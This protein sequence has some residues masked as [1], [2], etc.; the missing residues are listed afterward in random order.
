MMRRPLRVVQVLAEDAI[1]GTEAAVS[2]FAEILPRNEVDATVVTFSGPGPVAKGRR[3]AGLSTISLESA[4]PMVLRRALERLRPDVAHAYGF[5]ASMLTRAVAASVSG[6]KA[7]VGVRG[8][9]NLDCHDPRSVRARTSLRAEAS[10][11]RLVA[12]Y[13]A[14]SQGA[15]DL[16]VRA[17]VHSGKVVLNH[18]GV[19]LATWC[20]VRREGFDPPRLVCVARL[21]SL[22]GHDLLLRALAVLHERGVGPPLTLV[23]DGI[24]REELEAL[25][26]R[27]D[28]AGQIRFCGALDQAGVRH[29]LAAA[30][31]FC[32]AS[33]S[34]GSPGAVLEAMATG[35]PVVGTA[36]NGISDAVRDGVTGALVRDRTPA[37][38]AVALEAVLTA[39]PERRAAMGA[40][41]RRRVE[42]SFSEA[43]MVQRRLDLYRRVA[44]AR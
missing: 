14:N 1:G 3:A 21:T 20:P 8:L 40:A 42:H 19:D 33:L 38:F 44:G 29:E 26:G 5:R 18:N 16:L 7:V 10:T 30:D 32:L 35:L 13:E 31:V 11:Q 28:L 27:L 15:I 23:G 25:A 37:A 39:V 22:K 24:L 9:L 36:V 17:G 6:V 34:E 41:A 4:H 12:A 2:R 43:A